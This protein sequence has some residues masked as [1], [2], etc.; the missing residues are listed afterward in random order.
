[1]SVELVEDCESRFARLVEQ[2]AR[3]MTDDIE[4]IRQRYSEA[5][6]G[7]ELTFR[8]HGGDGD[9]CVLAMA[10]SYSFAMGENIEWLEEAALIADLLNFAAKL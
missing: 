8:A 10:D 6:R 1:M 7:K 9:Y 5:F 3:K 4:R 2:R